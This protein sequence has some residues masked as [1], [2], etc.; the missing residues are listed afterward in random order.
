MEFVDI[1]T[2]LQITAQK[3]LA[4]EPNYFTIEF[5]KKDGFRKIVKNARRF[6]KGV[7]QGFGVSEKKSNINYNSKELIM[8][9]EQKGLDPEIG[10][11]INIPISAIVKFNSRWIKH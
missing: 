7:N 9:F 6:V 4:G 11:F 3:E 1:G 8:V 10:Q 2:A 5:V